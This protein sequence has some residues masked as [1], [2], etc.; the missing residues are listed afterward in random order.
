MIDALFIFLAQG[1]LGWCFSFL[2]RPRRNRTQRT[3]A[4]Q[5]NIPLSKN[6]YSILLCTPPRALWVR[7]IAPSFSL[8]LGHRTALV[9]LTP[10]TTVLPLRYLWEARQTEQI[11][12]L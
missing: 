4:P 6:V 3:Y 11:P 8:Q 12:V 10:F 1:E 9:L 7:N 5:L 2:W